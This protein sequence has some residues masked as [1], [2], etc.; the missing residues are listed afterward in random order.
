MLH[1]TNST[2]I[3]NETFYSEAKRINTK[4]KENSSELERLS[5]IVNNPNSSRKEKKNVDDCMKR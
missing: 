2:W 1:S 4:F 5:T 3:I